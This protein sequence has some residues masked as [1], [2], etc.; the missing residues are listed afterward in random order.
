[1]LLILDRSVC[2]M[3][4]ILVMVDWKYIVMDS[5]VQYVMIA[6]AQLMLEL[7]AVS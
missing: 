7:P 3:E 2:K 6:L 4:L 5:G 1:M